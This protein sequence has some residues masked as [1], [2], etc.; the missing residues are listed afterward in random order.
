MPP[1]HPSPQLSEDLSMK[2]SWLVWTKTAT[3]EK[4]PKPRREFSNSLTPS[5]TVSL[6]TG[7]TWKKFG[8]IA[9]I[10]NSEFHQTSILPF[11]L[12][13]LVIPRQTDK[14]WQKSLLKHSKFL[15][16]ISLFRLSSPSTLQEELLVLCLML[17]MVL[18]IPYQFMRVMLF[19]MP[20]RE[21]I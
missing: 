13:L 14:K 18:L 8:I 3:S 19:P 12:K 15:P 16:T 10:M 17:E 6:T 11:S 21:T 5:S 4:K 2:I 1:D 20:L 9:S 7:M